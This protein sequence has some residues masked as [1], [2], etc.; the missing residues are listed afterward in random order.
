MSD[1]PHQPAQPEPVEP[2]PNP[3]GQMIVTGEAHIIRDGVVVTDD[4]PEESR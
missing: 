3:M 4:K 2:A 1:T